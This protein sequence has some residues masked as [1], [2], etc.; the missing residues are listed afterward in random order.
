MYFKFFNGW[1]YSFHFLSFQHSPPCPSTVWFPATPFARGAHARP[2]TLG[3]RELR[4][5]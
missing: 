1:Y 5:D 4:L 3:L 2:I